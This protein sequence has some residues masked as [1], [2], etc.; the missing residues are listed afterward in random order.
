MVLYATSTSF[1]TFDARTVVFCK[2]NRDYEPLL[3]AAD[4][5][6]TDDSLLSS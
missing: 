6:A 3:A 2:E 1:Y 5:T 4:E